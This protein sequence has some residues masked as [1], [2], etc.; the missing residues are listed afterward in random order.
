MQQRALA[1]AARALHRHD[2]PRRE[3]QADAAQRVVVAAGVADGDVDERRGR[4]AGEQ[5]PARLERRQGGELE[6]CRSGLERV[7]AGVVLR[8]DGA[9]RDEDL[10]REQQHDERRRERERAVLQP[11]AR[12]ERDERHRQRGDEVEGEPRQERPPQRADRL[13]AVLLRDPR[14]GGHL[15]GGPAVHLQRRQPLQEV[16][17]RRGQAREG[18]VRPLRAV[19]GR[20]AEHDEEQRGDREGDEQDAERDQVGAGDGDQ[21]ER[22][23]DDRLHDRRQHARDVA[24]ERVERRADRVGDPGGVAPADLER[25]GGGEPGERRAAQLGPGPLAGAAAE[26]LDEPVEQRP[27]DQHR[28][29]RDELARGVA[30]PD[31]CERLRQQ[32]RRRDRRRT[33]GRRER[34]EHR[35][36]AAQR[37]R[38]REQPGVERR[39]PPGALPAHRTGVCSGTTSRTETAGRVS[40]A[41]KTQYVHAW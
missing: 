28:G 17:Q 3:A 7:G 8:T 15:A 39:E 1:G 21:D 35:H 2:L 30:V 23:H 32:H 31:R 13:D 18:G 36:V 27:G 6:R 24:V 9:Q 10:R 29:E 4:L 12:G 19:A 37:G 25:S 20:E 14:D 11:Q 22:R 26:Q 38:R 40:R 16:E 33:A 34:D 41:R 5:A